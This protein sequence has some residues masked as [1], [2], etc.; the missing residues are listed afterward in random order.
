[1]LAAVGGKRRKGL[2]LL[3]GCA[4]FV[5]AAG[6]VGV[7]LVLRFLPDLRREEE[8]TR[9]ED[10]DYRFRIVHPGPG[11]RLMASDDAQS[12]NP[13]ALAGAM[14][15]TGG[16][17]GLVL[18]EHADGMDLAAAEASVVQSMMV[19]ASARS[20][21]RTVDF[22]GLPARRLALEGD[23]EGLVFHFD[24][25]VFLHRGYLYQ[26]F[27]ATPAATAD[28]G[29]HA[30]QFFAAFSILPG[31]VRGR[32][33]RIAVADQRGAGWRIASGRFESASYGLVLDGSEP[34]QL[35]DPFE[36]DASDPFAEAGIFLP[37]DVYV[38]VIPEV[39]V[40]AD[41][42]AYAED[43]R[44]RASAPGDAHGEPVVHEVAGRRVAFDSYTLDGAVPFHY[45]TGALPLDD[46]VVQIQVSSRSAERVDAALPDALARLRVL[47]SE[48]RRALHVDLESEPDTRVAVGD[49]WSIRAGVYRDFATGFRWSSPTRAWRVRGGDSATR[50]HEAARVSMELPDEGISGYVTLE[51]R[52]DADPAAEHRR[53]LEAFGVMPR[54][55]EPQT[56]TQQ[57]GAVTGL[58]TRTVVQ[59]GH[60][61]FDYELATAPVAGGTLSMLVWCA[62]SVR[63]EGRDAIG[64]AVASLELP[65][66]PMRPSAVEGSRHIDE[67]FGFAFDSPWPG[68]VPQDLTP[69]HVAATTSIVTVTRGRRFVMVFAVS[70]PAASVDATMRVVL[71]V[72]MDRLGGSNP[73]SSADEGA[74]TLGGRPATMKRVRTLAEDLALVTH[75]SGGTVYGVVVVQPHL[76]ATPFD[77]ITAGFR[78]LDPP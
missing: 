26:L 22:H 74:A 28:R 34:F 9:V 44:R 23:M 36:L 30:E 61:D 72:M 10:T 31:E 59:D 33:R 66:E 43:V 41:V 68:T 35:V 55:G 8:L 64:E 21:P 17:V 76:G 24:V 6:V 40:G 37:P 46:R 4:A 71:D 49:G 7:V 50:R 56:R 60:L 48:E 69:A 5:A 16:T 1:M 2:V 11:W 32:D 54:E 77:T 75:E 29:S 38:F 3:V 25:L 58:R 19:D 20:E 73:F 45:R 52:V 63:P 12:V 51:P 67:R 47:S 39:V 42:P 27:C 18:A 78:F 13:Y 15:A 62:G 65:G 53:L 70:S 14:N 57:L